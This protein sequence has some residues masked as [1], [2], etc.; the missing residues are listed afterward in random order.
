MRL[1]SDL[2]NERIGAVD[3]HGGNAFLRGAQWGFYFSEYV[4]LQA[5]QNR[6]MQ[7]SSKIDC[8]C[9][10]LQL[11]KA[12]QQYSAKDWIR[13]GQILREEGL[14]PKHPVVVVPGSCTH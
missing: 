2:G 1:C 8:C 11:Y 4:Q 10:C 3:V 14:R 5:G 9:M 13:P 6:L 7:F 12:R